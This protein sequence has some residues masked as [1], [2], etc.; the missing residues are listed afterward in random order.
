M[1]KQVLIIGLG[2]L[3]TSLAKTLSE[4]GM[5]V[6]AVDINKDIVDKNAVF[7]D[8]LFRCN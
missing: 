4:K 5:E 1:T 6:V 7:I 2:Q 3:G 8:D